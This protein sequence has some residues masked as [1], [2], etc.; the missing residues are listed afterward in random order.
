MRRRCATTMLLLAALTC[1]C[2]T[3]PEQIPVRHVRHAAP[4]RV[5]QAQIDAA[6]RSAAEQVRRCY[7]APRVSSAGRL[8]VTRV[9][10]RLTPD[11]G[12]AGLPIL[13]FQRGVTAANQSHA[14][15]MAEAAISAVMRCAP[16]HLDPELYAGGWREFDLTFSPLAAA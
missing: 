3:M 10:V 5:Q 15:P 8:I 6:L 12:L 4:T 9:R 16:L 13:L 14:A 1:G 2:G 7:R 11:G